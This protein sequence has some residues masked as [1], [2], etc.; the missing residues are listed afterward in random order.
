[1]YKPKLIKTQ[2]DLLNNVNNTLSNIKKSMPR[3]T[4]YKFKPILK[5]FMNKLRGDKK[6]SKELDDHLNKKNV[7]TS[8]DFHYY[9]LTKN[10]SAFNDRYLLY[11]SNGD[12]NS[13]INQYFDKIR[14]GLHDLI[15]Y[16]KTQGEWKVQLSMK[17]TFVSFIDND[18]KQIMHTKGHNET[19]M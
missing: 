4:I 7:N 2:K 17:V 18:R 12:N 14:P 9:R 3:K 6:L 8:G 16:Q 10:R 5:G 1:M 19:I 13:S 15:D 11:T